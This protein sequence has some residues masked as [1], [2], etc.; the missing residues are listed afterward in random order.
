VPIFYGKSIPP[1]DKLKLASQH[2]KNIPKIITIIFS[3]F[4]I[5]VFRDFYVTIL[6]SANDYKKVAKNLQKFIL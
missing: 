4:Y 6:Y 5:K 3:I 2:Q 1:Y